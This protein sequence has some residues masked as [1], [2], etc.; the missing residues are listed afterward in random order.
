MQANTGV[1]FYV[2]SNQVSLT[3]NNTAQTGGN[4]DL[5]RNQLLPTILPDS[6]GHPLLYGYSYSAFRDVTALVKAYAAQPPAGQFNYNGHAIY[7]VNCSQSSMCD[8][9]SDNVSP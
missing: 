1:Q 3:A 5:N 9:Y 2:N 7:K 4:T 8:I 6:N